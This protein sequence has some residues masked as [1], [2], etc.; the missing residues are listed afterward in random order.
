MVVNL[1]NAGIQSSTM[2]S[3]ILG[4]RMSWVAQSKMVMGGATL[5]VLGS[6]AVVAFL[7]LGL[8]KWIQDVG[9]VV[10][11]LVF[12]ALIA[13]PFAITRLVAIRSTLLSRCRCPQSHCSA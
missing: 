3:Y 13:L 8:G 5:I 1:S 9:A 2:L 7:G 11:V 10:M 6:L 4:P 12:L